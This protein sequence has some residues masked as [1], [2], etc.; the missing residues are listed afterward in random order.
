[1]GAL[2]AST[3]IKKFLRFTIIASFC[4]TCLG[5]GYAKGNFNR[6]LILETNASQRFKG[7]SP[8][9][10]YIALILVCGFQILKVRTR[11]FV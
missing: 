4:T 11:S 3:M 9:I 5:N 8:K 1:M 10:T 2:T 7:V 6:V